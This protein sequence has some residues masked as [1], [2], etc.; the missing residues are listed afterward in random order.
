MKT[1]VLKTPHAHSLLDDPAF[2]AE[3]VKLDDHLPSIDNVATRQLYV[4]PWVDDVAV[5]PRSSE[6]GGV[7]IQLGGLLALMCIGAGV[8]AAVFHDGLALLLR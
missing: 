2:V 8:A 1:D 3:L 5:R 4:P 7:L 6:A